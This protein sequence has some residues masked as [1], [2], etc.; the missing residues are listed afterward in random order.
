LAC[1]D[2]FVDGARLL[3]KEGGSNV[4]AQDKKGWT[5]LMFAAK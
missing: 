1:F 5:P 2:N 3:V 4:N